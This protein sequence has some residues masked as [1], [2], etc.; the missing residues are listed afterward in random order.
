MSEG[1]HQLL[2]DGG[3]GGAGGALEAVGNTVAVYAISFVMFLF[4][5]S[6]LICVGFINIDAAAVG[7][8]PLVIIHG[9]SRLLIAVFIT[10]ILGRRI[11]P[12]AQSC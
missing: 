9:V 1:A 6:V 7:Y 2:D 8:G 12:T 5:I 4:A 11:L 3:S 10:T